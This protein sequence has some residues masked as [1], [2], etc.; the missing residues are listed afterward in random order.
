M[1]YLRLKGAFVSR[2]N[3][4]GVYDRRLH[5]YRCGTN[6]KGLPDILATYK[7]ISLMIEVKAG[8]DRLSED[9]K[10]ARQEQELSG[11]LSFVAHNFTE[12]KAW[13]DNNI[14]TI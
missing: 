1:A 12:F 6:R 11:G 3:N 14:S 5:R 10:K 2:L 8:K 13:F 7:G 9:Q 4:T